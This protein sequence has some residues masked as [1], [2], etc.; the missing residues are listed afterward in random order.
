MYEYMQND[1]MFMKY[2]LFYKFLSYPMSSFEALVTGSNP[3]SLTRTGKTWEQG[4]QI[5][6]P[7]SLVNLPL[8]LF[9]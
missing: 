2:H 4:R 3:V 1:I 8:N 5:A 9:L 6:W 7:C